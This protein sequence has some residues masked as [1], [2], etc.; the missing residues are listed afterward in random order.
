M[1]GRVI[2][3]GDVHG[4][5]VALAALIRAIDLRADDTLVMLGDY[6]D[7][8]I[9]TRGVIDLLIELRDRC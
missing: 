7:R 4:C 9:D 8:G 5:S 6:C 2:A 3:V 1:A